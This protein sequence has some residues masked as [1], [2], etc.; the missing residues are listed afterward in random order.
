MRDQDCGRSM[1]ESFATL[2]HDSSSWKTSQRCLFEGWIPFSETLPPAGTMQNGK[3]YWRPTLLCRIVE[4]ESLLLPTP[5]KSF[6]QRGWGLSRTGRQRYSA[7]IQ[8][9]AF[10]FGYKPPVS[11]LEWM[12]G[13]QAGF[14]DIV[15]ERWETLSS[16]RLRNGLEG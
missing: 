10:Q 16:R 1:H 11:L 4:N 8:A 15:Q 6:G 13:Y 7:E 3:L 5:T 9:N 2:D 12:M 14:T